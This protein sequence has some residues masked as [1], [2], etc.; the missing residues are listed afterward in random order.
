MKIELSLYFYRHKPLWVLLILIILGCALQYLILDGTIDS[1]KEAIEVS[2]ETL[3]YQNFTMD[4]VF[5][6]ALIYY[7]YCAASSIITD[8]RNGVLMY[9][10]V[11]NISTLNIMSKKLGSAYIFIL[12]GN[13]V[14]IAAITLVSYMLYGMDAQLAAN[15]LILLLA[16]TY[17]ALFYA[18]LAIMFALLFNN[19]VLVLSIMF[20]MELAKVGSYSLMK[21]WPIYDFII[22]SHLDISYHF[23]LPSTGVDR[24]FPLA[25]TLLIYV[26][27]AAA[28]IALSLY[29]FNKKRGSLL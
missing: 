24:G 25:F 18:T 27:Y 9:S 17:T 1:V 23:D 3:I 7:I 8:R 22:L 12:I 26:M 10:F 19:Y 14:L 15:A 20:I 16:K 2:S 13:T 5:F 6:L 4:T 29:I 11:K 21:D 28:L